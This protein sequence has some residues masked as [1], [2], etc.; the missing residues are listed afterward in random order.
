MTK[1]SDAL[2]HTIKL[3]TL[4]GNP[5]NPRILKDDKFKKL[6]KSIE[7]FPKMMELRPIVIDADNIVLGGNMRLKALKE[8]KYKDIPNT[9]VK[10]AADLTEKEKE[11]FIIKDNVGFG[12]WDWD[13]LANEW[14]N[15]ELIEWGLDI[16]DI[17][18]LEPDETIGDDEVPEKAP[19]ITVK[20]DLYE[21]GEHR[22]LCG[23]STLIDDVEKLMDGDN[24][25]FGFCDPPYNLNFEYNKY[26]DNKTDDEYISFS[27]K[28]FSNLQLNT[29]RQAVTLGT[30]NI[31]VM[32]LLG[33]VAGVAC[34][35]KKNWITS[36]KIAKL[37]Q[38]EPIFFYGDYTKHKRTSDLYE[39]NRVVQKDVG[40]NHTCPKQI[41]L[42]E[43]IL[44]NYSNKSVLDLFGGSGT[45]LIACEKTKRKC[46]MI[47]LD[48][49]YCDVIVQ[50]YVD[51][52]KTNNKEYS[53]TR[54]GVKCSD[55]E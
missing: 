24:A 46:Y 32:A 17:T 36:C 6:I 31:S 22:V 42:I 40:N 47:E 7:E 10:R 4:K 50:R 15:E 41:K 16:P 30:H 18:F 11:Q 53:V 38:W 29:T 27:K 25:D 48:E 5:N 49:H 2:H 34:W 37:Q 51:F 12:E 20:G 3:S 8:L 28:W 19:S 43:E 14:E 33:D 9:W 13:I 26:E 54:N 55:F 52:C 23:D 1:K 35:V 21:L 44:I 39:I 45:T